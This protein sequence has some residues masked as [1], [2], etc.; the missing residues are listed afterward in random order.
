MFPSIY[1]VR[2]YPLAGHE[3]VSYFTNMES[4]TSR[5]F[6]NGIYYP[7]YTI[8]LP[9]YWLIHDEPNSDHA[10]LL[11]HVGQNDYFSTLA[12]ILRFYEES[13]H[14]KNIT[15]E[16]R[17]L[18]LKTIKDVMND[19]LYLNKKYTILPKDKILNR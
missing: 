18:Q 3:V 1:P 13:I 17:E 15:P 11:F 14:E 9:K 5:E 8:N 12:T 6:S 10:S 4:N 2:E 7:L 16:M 19:L